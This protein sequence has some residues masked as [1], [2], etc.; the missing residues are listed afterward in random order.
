MGYQTYKKV[1]ISKQVDVSQSPMFKISVDYFNIQK[2]IT[3]INTKF[4]Y[5]YLEVPLTLYKIIRD[6]LFYVILFEEV[7]QKINVVTFVQRLFLMIRLKEL[8][9]VSNI[10]HLK[11]KQKTIRIF[12]DF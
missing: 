8:N 2:N 3:T 9:S 7:K 5:P 11:Q 4:N 6:G 12:S 1:I 10:T